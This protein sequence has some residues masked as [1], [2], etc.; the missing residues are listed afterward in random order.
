[1][2]Q[3]RIQIAPSLAC[4]D[5]CNLQEHMR[6]FEEFKVDWIHYDVMDGHF[7]PNIT[8]GPE[9]QAKI[10]KMTDIPIDTHL[11]IFEPDKYI[12]KFVQAGSDLISVHAEATPHLDRTL[13]FIKSFGAKPA[14]AVNP[15]TPLSM[16]EYVLEIVDVV[17]IMTVN[18]GFAGQKLVPYTLDKISQVRQMIDLKRLDVD[19]EVDGN[20]SLENIPKMVAAGANIL[21]VGT[22]SLFLRNKNLE[23]ASADIKKLINNYVNR[24]KE[25]CL[26][27]IG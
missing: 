22:S 7:V 18:P 27:G 26:K 20:V 25:K 17:L 21:V 15:A 24:V 5:F 23:R 3:R 4:D 16:I 13:N 11:M 2:K 19:I 1:M 14:V 8:F 6:L 9:V 12:E 10:N